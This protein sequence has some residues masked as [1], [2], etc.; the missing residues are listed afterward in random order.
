MLHGETITSLTGSRD[1]SRQP[2][3][4]VVVLPRE[5]VSLQT[6]RDDVGDLIKGY[7]SHFSI[8]DEGLSLNHT[9]THGSFSVD[10][11]WSAVKIIMELFK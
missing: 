6:K 5:P 2:E 4:P 10:I 7:R 11:K 9:S 1:E 3:L 8:K